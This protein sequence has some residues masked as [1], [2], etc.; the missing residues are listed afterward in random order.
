MAMIK[1]YPFPLLLSSFFPTL[2]KSGVTQC[3]AALHELPQYRALS[4]AEGSYHFVIR[5]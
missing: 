3:S 4:R 5:V 1:L 2:R